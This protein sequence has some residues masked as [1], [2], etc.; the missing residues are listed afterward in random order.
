MH[1]NCF[2]LRHYQSS[3]LL[4]F[5]SKV[6]STST[7]AYVWFSSLE[8]IT[9]MKTYISQLS[10]TLFWFSLRDLGCDME[11]LI[12][13]AMHCLRQP[14]NWFIFARGRCIRRE[15]AFQSHPC[16][17]FQRVSRVKNLPVGSEK[18][19]WDER[20]NKLCDI[21]HEHQAIRWHH[22]KAV[23]AFILQVEPCYVDR[24]HNIYFIAKITQSYEIHFETGCSFNGNLEVSQTQQFQ[25]EMLKGWWLC[26]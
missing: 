23:V 6:G 10:S 1:K 24:F 11:D 4:Q 3:T 2:N 16:H 9:C 22:H 25:V 7:L 21:T 19:S 13:C 14:G 8:W 26:R 17:S 5:W 18:G 12:C 15:E 20:Y